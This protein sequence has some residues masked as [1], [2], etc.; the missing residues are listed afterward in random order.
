MRKYPL[1]KSW[2][3]FLI[4][5]AILAIVAQGWL[6]GAHLP[7]PAA[8]THA[9]PDQASSPSNV[10]E[11]EIRKRALMRRPAFQTG[12]I[13]P[14]WGADAYGQGDGNWQTG[15]REIQNQTEAQWVSMTIDFAQASPG[16]SSIQ[17]AR[18]TPS[19][20]AVAQGIRLARAMGYH[21]LVEP[22]ITIQGRDNWAG[23]IQ[24]ADA[25]QAQTWFDNY[26]RIYRPYI[27][28]AA[29]AGADE[30]SLG[31]EY[32]QIQGN[33][34]AQWNQLIASVHAIYHGSL[35]YSIN[36]TSLAQRQPP[37]MHNPL[38]HFIG[39]TMYTPLTAIPRRLPPAS[40]AGLWREKI[41]RSLDAFSTQ[42]KK[43]VLIS[44]IGYRNSPD[45]LYD[46]WASQTL[47]GR[48]PQ[49]QAAAYNAALRDVINDPLIM[50]IFFW[51]WS[52]PPYAPNGE[53]AAQVLY[54][55]YTSPLS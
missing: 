31:C 4:G 30:L 11:T 23:Y 43:P 9:L 8:H 46:P 48:D 26:W 27:A 44:E 40:I 53:P 33:W 45:A 17:V 47:P 12:V 28:A 49:E 41:G 5:L 14:Q 20:Q 52:F 55:W 35:I 50:G 37:W 29:Q 22:L 18:N 1:F 36:W 38:L 51:A 13:F 10:Q 3:R 21:V 54:N 19:P 6:F 42:L 32:E 24:F 16:A 39:V 15:L 7:W 2:Q 34:S 25:A